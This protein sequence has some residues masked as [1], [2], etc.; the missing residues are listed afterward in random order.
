MRGPRKPRPCAHAQLR[1]T[2]EAEAPRSHAPPPPAAGAA[3]GAPGAEPAGLGG[4]GLVGGVTLAPRGK[5]VNKSSAVVR[6]LNGSSG[7]QYN[8]TGRTQ[9]TER[10]V[11]EY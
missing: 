1:A 7:M 11:D 5:T 2:A 9:P 8:P 3:A 10:P 6:R 4:G